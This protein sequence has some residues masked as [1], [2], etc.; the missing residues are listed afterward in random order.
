MPPYALTGL[1]GI[2]LCLSSL[3]KH[4]LMPK[5]FSTDCVIKSNFV[6]E[7][8]PTSK[9]VRFPEPVGQKDLLLKVAAYSQSG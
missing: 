7:S 8:L 9:A 1:G 6:G 2:G 3:S 5:G 4:R